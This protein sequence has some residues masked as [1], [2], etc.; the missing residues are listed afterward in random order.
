MTNGTVRTPA[1]ISKELAKAGLNIAAKKIMTPATVAAGFFLRRKMRTVLVFGG[2]G[3][4]QPIASAGIE[5]IHSHGDARDVEKADAIF[6]GWHRTIHMDEIEAACRAVW[7]GA[8]LYAASM[9]PFFA[10]RDGR[11][12]GSS[13]AIAAM[14][15]AFTGRRA[16]ALGK[17]SLHVLRDAALH[18]GCKVSELVVVGDDPALEVRMALNG[19]ALAVALQTGI[20]KAAEF[21]ALP[22]G[23]APHAC[24]ADAAAFFEYL[25]DRA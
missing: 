10:T 9:V 23:R 1:D 18:V 20:A 8:A 11:A 5:V 25:A 14:I 3:V 16:T 17:P 6:I 15:T 24:F 7:N 4:W 2:A 22:P 13:R 21:A 19:K 12:L